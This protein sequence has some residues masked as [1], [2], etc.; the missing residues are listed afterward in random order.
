MQAFLY[1]GISSE[2]LDV[3]P[4]FSIRTTNPRSDVKEKNVIFEE[5]NLLPLGAEEGGLPPVHADQPSMVY[6]R[7]SR[8][9]PNLNFGAVL[10]VCY[11]TLLEQS[12]RA[13]KG[14]LKVVIIHPLEKLCPPHL[15]V[16]T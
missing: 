4:V 16:T 10:N 6:K 3:Y 13:A 5:P 14:T 12:A 7:Y 9:L 2:E 15:Q 8:Y 1:Y 11:L